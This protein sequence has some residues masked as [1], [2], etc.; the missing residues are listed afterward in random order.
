MNSSNWR[1]AKGRN[2]ECGSVS[3]LIRIAGFIVMLP[4]PSRPE[5]VS[6][7]LPEGFKNMLH[8][9]KRTDT[10]TVFPLLPT[11]MLEPFPN[12]L[13][14]SHHVSSAEPTPTAAPATTSYQW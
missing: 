7:E 14:E 2:E 13:S 6:A 9:Y 5:D 4:A 11:A 12:N 10:S 1:L 8:L 3:K